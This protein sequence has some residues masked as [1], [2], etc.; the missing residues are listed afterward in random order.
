MHIVITGGAGFIGSHLTDFLL[1]KGYYVNIFDNLSSGK[2]EFVSHNFSHSKFKFTQVDLLDYNKLKKSL[3]S[4]ID[5]I[6][7]LAANSDVMKGVN[8]PDIDFK[9]STLATFN[10]L[11]AM[12][13][14]NIKNLFYM[15]GSG[16]YGNVGTRFVQENYGPLFP[17]SLYGAT[18]FSAEVMIYTFSY[19]Y[20][21]QV[22]VLRPANIIG[23]RATHGVIFD[24]INQLNKN[25]KKLPILGDGKQCKSYLYITDLLEGIDTVWKKGK[26]PINLYN[27]SSTTFIEVNKIAQ[28][29]IQEMGLKNVKIEKTGGAGGWKGDVPIIKLDSSKL[30]KL[31]WKPKLTSLQAVRKTVR[32]LLKKNNE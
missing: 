21:L 24:F 30:E 8:D 18:K 26:R 22:W 11:K 5:I 17:V 10:L 9:N 25:P 14:N 19:L 3:A 29:V 32:I 13:K 4:D 28:I 15:S 20:N 6:F 27:I 1:K 2:K 12:K 16:I 7:H 31:G 23:P